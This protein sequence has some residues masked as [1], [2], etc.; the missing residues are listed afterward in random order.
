MVILAEYVYDVF[1]IYAKRE[2]EEKRDLVT[3][4]TAPGLT[5]VF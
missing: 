1:F 5:D 3:G 2:M 4:L